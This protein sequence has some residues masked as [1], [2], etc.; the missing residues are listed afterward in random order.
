VT[1]VYY[2]YLI[3]E[4]EQGMVYANKRTQQGIWRNL[5]DF[6][7]IESENEITEAD[8]LHQATLTKLLP[9]D[10]GLSYFGYENKVYKHILSHRKIFAYFH[11]I[12]VSKP[13]NYKSN[14]LIVPLSEFHRLAIPKLIE[15]FLT[16]SQLS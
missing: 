16:D 7:L 10:E 12:K 1:T 9:K 11:R 15:N 14:F 3:I 13:L 2:H 8:V 6:P 4:D 5:H